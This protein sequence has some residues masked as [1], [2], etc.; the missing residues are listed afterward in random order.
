MDE[1]G[2]HIDESETQPENAKRAMH[3]SWEPA[4]KVAVESERHS[5][6]QF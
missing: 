1:E 3:N 6:K 5:V 4:S 2:K